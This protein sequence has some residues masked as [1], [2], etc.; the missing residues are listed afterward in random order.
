VKITRLET[1]IVEIPVKSP[2]VFS[3]GVLK[4][5]SN[6]LVWIHTDEG[7]VGI[8]ESS[9]VPGGGVSEEAPES[10]KPM[11]DNY[12]AP[13]VIGEDPFDIERIHQKMDAVIPRNLIAKCGI[14]LALWDLMGKAVGQPACKLLGGCFDSEILCTYTLSIDTPEKMAEQASF[15]KSQGYRTLVVKIGR[16]PAT[17]LQR[18]AQVREAVGDE[19]N[20]RLDANEAYWPDQAI[21]II[22]RMEKYHPEFVE[23]P[24]KRWDLDGMAKVARAVDTPISSDE[25]NTSLES[26]M[27]IIQKEAAGIINIKISKNGGLYR[28]KKIA[29]LAEAAGIPCIVGGANTYEVGRQACRHFAVST[30]Q[31]QMGMGSEGCAPASQS[32]IDDVTRTIMTYEDVAKGKGF[33]GVLPGPGLG[34]ELDEEKI[35]QYSAMSH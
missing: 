27:Q 2:Y 4:A 30:A 33:V 13:V 26:V 3:H 20:L 22:R 12:L 16:D 17:D 24:V 35:Q 21:G 32:K 8:G 14:D 1:R 6:V 5:F 18:L 11:I 9:F 15:R 31:A 25:S 19:V 23:E 7:I 34:V 29:A 10:T 28:S